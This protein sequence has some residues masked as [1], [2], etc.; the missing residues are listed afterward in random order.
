MATSSPLASGAK[1]AA[2]PGPWREFWTAFSANR[3]AVIGLVTIVA[4]LLVALF[5]PWIA[6][7]APNETNSAVFLKPPAWQQGGSMSY[8][9]GTDAI[10]RDILSRL[11]YGA[12]LSL[13]IG[14][15]VVALSVVVGVVLGLVAGFFRGVLEI[16]IMRLMDIVL[17]LPSLLLAIVIVAILGPGLVNAMLAVAIVVLPHYVRITRAAV[18]AEV[19]RD[20]VTAA[21]VSGAGTL[22]L[23]FSEVLPNCAAPLIVQASLGI[24][25]AILDAAALG[26]LGLGAQPPSP[27]WGTMLAD[28]REFVLRAW[29]VV[30]FPGLAILAA[31]LAFNLLGDGLRDA[32]DPKLKR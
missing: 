31:V 10:G 21:R 29:W 12:R 22:R 25:T 13:S 11:M 23:M 6:P 8:L 18:I 17:T 28:A 19:S 26:F 16:A 20:Y 2:P 5:A 9:L 24:S 4:L 1:T 14:V 30:T 15:A 3:G 32:L 7:H 27:E